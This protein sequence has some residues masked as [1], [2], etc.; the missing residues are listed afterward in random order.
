MSW[1]RGGEAKEVA[2]RREDEERKENKEEERETKRAKKN[3][4]PPQGGKI[5][6]TTTTKRTNERT[7]D[8]TAAGPSCFFRFD[9]CPLQSNGFIRFSAAP[10]MLFSLFS[11]TLFATSTAASTP[12]RPPRATRKAF[13]RKKIETLREG[14][15]ALSLSRNFRHLIFFFP[16]RSRFRL[17]R[18]E[19][20]PPCP[21]NRSTPSSTLLT[22]REPSSSHGWAR[23]GGN[24]LVEVEIGVRIGRR[25][26][27]NFDFFLRAF[28]RDCGGSKIICSRFSLNVFLSLFLSLSARP[29]QSLTDGRGGDRHDVVVVCFTAC[30]CFFQRKKKEEKD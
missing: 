4:T 13:Q 8:A 29:V 10:L 22:S 19:F 23:Y 24:L 21:P 25:K 16:A 15:R 1:G 18:S 3:E 17:T 2:C 27:E 5:R 6:T 26:D 30:Y 20:T 14:G 7:N 28:D 11:S 9:R 12:P